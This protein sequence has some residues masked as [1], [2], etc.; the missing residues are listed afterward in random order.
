MKMKYTPSRNDIVNEY[1]DDLN[2]EITPLFLEIRACILDAEPAFNESIKW[3]D[4][5]VYGTTKNHIQTVVGKG[6]ISLIFFEGVSIK[7]EFGL[8]EGEGKKTRT[9]R[10][11]SLD[12]NKE[13]LKYYVH[14]TVGNES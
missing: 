10:I 9:M 6:K 13:A 14:Q 8:L 5:L 1:I 2:E 3:K 7:D 11:R 4:C 12:F